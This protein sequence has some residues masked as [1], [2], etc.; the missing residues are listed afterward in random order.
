MFAT[1]RGMRLLGLGSGRSVR[2]LSGGVLRDPGIGAISLSV[3]T[4][5]VPACREY[6]FRH[7]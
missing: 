7:S 6:G 3:G 4:Q 5:P 1:T 2:R